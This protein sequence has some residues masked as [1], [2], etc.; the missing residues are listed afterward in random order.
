MLIGLA[1]FGVFAFVA[2]RALD[3]LDRVG[4]VMRC[5]VGKRTADIRKFV[6]TVASGQC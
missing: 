4:R 5:L 1:E 6:A 3:Q 2:F